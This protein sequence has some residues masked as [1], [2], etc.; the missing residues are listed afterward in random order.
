MIACCLARP[1][2]GLIFGFVLESL[3]SFLAFSELPLNWL[4]FCFLF[5]MYDT[6]V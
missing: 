5:I 6:F 1:V 4:I 3:L 2:L